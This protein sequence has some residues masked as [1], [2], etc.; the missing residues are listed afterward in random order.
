M[1]ELKILTMEENKHII[2]PQLNTGTFVEL[3]ELTTKKTINKKRLIQQLP[4][5]NQEARALLNLRDTN[6]IAI[7]K[8]A[9]KR[10]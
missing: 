1:D 10:R 6:K 3:C 8:T 7:A 5:I 9:Y 4:F 2:E